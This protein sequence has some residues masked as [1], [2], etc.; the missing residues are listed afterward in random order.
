MATHVKPQSGSLQIDKVTN[1][2]CTM[3]NL[4]SWPP[5]LSMSTCPRPPLPRLQ[6]LWSWTWTG[7][8]SGPA[9]T[10][11][12]TWSGPPCVM[13][14]LTAGTD[15]VTNASRKIYNLLTL[16]LL[17]ILII[18]HLESCLNCLNTEIQGVPKKCARVSSFPF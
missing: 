14:A 10:P 6:C 18:F 1:T 7:P 11:S 8:G 3:Y 2:N 5:Y 15:Q 16:F 17:K 4:S 12:S 9:P 13:T